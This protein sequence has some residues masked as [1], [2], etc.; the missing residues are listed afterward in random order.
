MEPSAT[1]TDRPAGTR[2]P[3]FTVGQIVQR[4]RGA[5]EQQFPAAVWVEGELSNCSY[6]ASGHIYF[7]L[8]DDQVTDRLGQPIVLPCAFFRGANQHLKV[9]LEDGMQFHAH[10]VGADAGDAIYVAP[11]IMPP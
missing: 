4:I 7:T 3:V 5:I 8:V 2:I 1:L 9:R 6:A 10:R 11:P